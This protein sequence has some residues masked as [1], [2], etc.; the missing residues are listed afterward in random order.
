MQKKIVCMLTAF[1]LLLMFA[2]SSCQTEAS[3][4]TGLYKFSDYK[5]YLHSDGTYRLNKGTPLSSQ[6]PQT[7][8]YEIH[9]K[10]I[11]IGAYVFELDQNNDLVV[12]GVVP[13]ISS[14]VSKELLEPVPWYKRQMSETDGIFKAGDVFAY[15]P[16]YEQSRYAES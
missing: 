8:S 7:G 11:Y 15:A 9:E 10:M 1:L 13:N 3:P 5:L 16:Q 2:L 6:G 12:I 4:R 14:G